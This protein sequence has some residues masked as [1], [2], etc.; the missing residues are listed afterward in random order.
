MN[1]DFLA[2]ALAS[3]SDT[4]NDTSLTRTYISNTSPSKPLIAVRL[5][6]PYINSLKTSLIHIK[7]K[8]SLGKE[9]SM[10]AQ[11]PSPV[12][13]KRKSTN[14][15]VDIREENITK[16][17]KLEKISYSNAYTA[18]IGA[19]DEFSRP[20]THTK[21]EIAFTSTPFNEEI[22]PIELQDIENSLNMKKTST[23]MNS[24]SLKVHQL[25]QFNILHDVFDRRHLSQ[26][27]GDDLTCRDNLNMNG[28]PCIGNNQ[29]SVRLNLNK[30][31][32]QYWPINLVD[33]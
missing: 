20:F 15:T 6:R 10:S 4:T 30:G 33:F 17:V 19:Y 27:E 29:S 9:K 23:A 25:E 32:F 31:G 8:Q 11:L 22:E 24:P 7:E 28:F 26:E 2:L 16:K 1:S 3:D 5:S 12:L 13:S 21:F 14:Q 18:N